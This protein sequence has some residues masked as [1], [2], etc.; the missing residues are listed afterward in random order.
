MSEYRQTFCFRS[1]S[2]KSYTATF[3]FDDEEHMQ[4]YEEDNFDNCRPK[5]QEWLNHNFPEEILT[6]EG[7]DIEPDGDA[8]T[9]EDCVDFRTS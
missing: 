7:N 3:I 4:M 6:S 8:A 9:I 1:E 2:D 5:V